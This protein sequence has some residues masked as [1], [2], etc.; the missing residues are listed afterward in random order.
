ML[1]LAIPRTQ[2]PELM[3]MPHQQ[4][5]RN[6][7]FVDTGPVTPIMSDSP[8]TCNRGVNYFGL[9]SVTRLVAVCAVV[10]AVAGGACTSNADQAV[11]ERSTGVARPVC[12]TVGGT[13]PGGGK[14]FYVDKSRPAGSQCFE[15]A[16]DA[17]S[18]ATDPLAAWGCFG[19][20]IL[21]AAGTGIGTGE[22]NTTAVADGCGTAGIAAK[23]ADDYA[24]GSQTNWFLP[25]K[26]ELNQLCKY[27]WGYTAD[28]TAISNGQSVAPAQQANGCISTSPN[29]R[30][31]GFAADFY[32]SSSQSN[33]NDAWVQNFGYG[34]QYTD[35]KFNSLR[36]RPVRA[37]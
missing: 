32:W 10:V 29:T 6:R 26:A 15:A 35:A 20:G 36:V 17:W 4:L 13:G 1:I 22:G 30:Q 28:G 31:G 27:A 3:T 18:G 5:R 37:F 9:R 34:G 2:W 8:V 16:P 14:I 11:D 24:G 7:V 23:L 33:P 21:G 12:G 19:T 25:S